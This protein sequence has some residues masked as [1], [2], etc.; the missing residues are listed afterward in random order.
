MN[1]DPKQIASML[2]NT[3]NVLTEGVISE[4]DMGANQVILIDRNGGSAIGPF[5]SVE[6]AKSFHQEWQ[7]P[8]QIAGHSLTSLMSPQSAVSG[9]QRGR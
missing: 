7:G 2:D 4:M 6:E 9:F 1:F 5:S 3:G 8:L